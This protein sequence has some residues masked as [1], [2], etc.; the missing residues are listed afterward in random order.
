MKLE[1]M[2]QNL[3]VLK[4]RRS[5]KT[6]QLE[7]IPIDDLQFCR[8]LDALSDG[9]F[10]EAHFGFWNDRKVIILS[11]DGKSPFRQK[12]VES[13]DSPFPELDIL[14]S[15][16]RHRNIIRVLGY[17]VEDELTKHLVLECFG[18]MTLQDYLYLYKDTIGIKE[19]I[20]LT[21]KIAKAIRFLHRHNIVHCD[22]GSC[23]ILVNTET[24]EPKIF[25]FALSR[26]VENPIS[27]PPLG[28]IRSMAPE[29]VV[30]HRVSF[31]SDTWQ[32]GIL[33]YEFVTG[34]EPFGDMCKDQVYELL[35]SEEVKI[36]VPK[37]TPPLFHAL[38]ASTTSLKTESRPTFSSILKILRIPKLVQ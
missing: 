15:L 35:K 23:N 3:N 11:M 24:L 22:I 8:A 5:C 29:Q 30:S 14:R 7:E 9:A 37:S 2:K 13:T 31:A 1:T 18:Q 33:L 21:R 32:F 10:Y 28:P 26:K 19:M 27:P 36:Y 12:L 4:K 16:P 25:K 34:T 6:F 17:C 38:L 20:T